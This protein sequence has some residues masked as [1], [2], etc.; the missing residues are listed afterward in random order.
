MLMKIAVSI[1]R[2]G[3]NA[4]NGDSDKDIVIG[5]GRVGEC[6]RS[7]IDSPEEIAVRT[8]I[9]TDLDVADASKLDFF[10]RLFTPEMFCYN[11]WAN[12]PVCS[13][14]RGHT[15][16]ALQEVNNRPYCAQQ[17]VKVEKNE[18]PRNLSLFSQHASTD[19]AL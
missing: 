18:S 5:T 17:R 2:T 19:M 7:T 8:R 4:S 12:K 14:A 13:Q 1:H 10:Y 6:G 3:V 9:N 16:P 11:S 15:K